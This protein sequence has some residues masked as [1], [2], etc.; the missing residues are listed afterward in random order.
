[1]EQTVI[2]NNISCV[3]T[4][5]CIGRNSGMRKPAFGLP[6]TDT[7]N[8]VILY[9]EAA[10]PSKLRL[11]AFSRLAIMH[12]TSYARFTGKDVMLSYNS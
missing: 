12:I 3:V 2:N 10:V 1:M 8:L 9:P 7:E 6:P 4:A 5:M 11:A